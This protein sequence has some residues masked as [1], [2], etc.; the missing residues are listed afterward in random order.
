[1]HKITNFIKKYDFLLEV[2]YFVYLIS[3]F[4]KLSN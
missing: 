3:E 1:M 2:K 4:L